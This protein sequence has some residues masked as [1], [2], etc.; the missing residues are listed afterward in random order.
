MLGRM[1]EFQFARNS[2]GFRRIEY[3]VQHAK[4]VRVQLIHHDANQIGIR[5]MDINQVF[6]TMRDIQD[7]AALGHFDM[8]PA[9]LRADEH[10]QVAGA[11]ALVFVIMAFGCPRVAGMTVRTSLIS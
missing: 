6:E 2:S 4:R 9:A 10:K 1:M 7:R 5:K 8:P 3:F 11:L